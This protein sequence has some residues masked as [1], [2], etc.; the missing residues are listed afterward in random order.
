MDWMNEHDRYFEDCLINDRL[1][2]NAEYRPLQK[3]LI[4][5]EPYERLI[6]YYSRFVIDPGYGYKGEWAYADEHRQFDLREKSF[7]AFIDIMRKLAPDAYQHHLIPQT[8]R[9]DLGIFDKIIN[10]REIDGYF[11]S[12]AFPPPVW[13][14]RMNRHDYGRPVIH[15]LPRE[16]RSP[17]VPAYRC[18]YDDELKE[19]TQRKIYPDDYRLLRAYFEQEK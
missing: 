4:V 17:S 11:K 16:L 6:S 12:R 18:F 15:D 3:V 1:L 19:I 5:R 13:K 2:T 7:A 9:I 10:I 8:F 14:N